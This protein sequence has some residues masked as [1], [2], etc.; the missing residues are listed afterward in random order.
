MVPFAFH[1]ELWFESSVP[2]YVTTTASLLPVYYHLYCV[3]FV[4]RR[5][6]F[7]VWKLLLHFLSCCT[8]DMSYRLL[9]KNAKQL[10]MI[11]KNHEKM[12]C[13]KA[14][15]DI[16]VLNDAYALRLGVID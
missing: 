4:V 3:V 11:T 7:G 15:N 6:G 9:V 2:C 13:G 12:L 8:L 5:S 16:V 10:V 14:M 1:R